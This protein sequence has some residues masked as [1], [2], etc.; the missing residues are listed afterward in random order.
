MVLC[1]NDEL[2]HPMGSDLAWRESLYFNFHDTANGIGGWI[3]LWVVPNQPQ[4]SGMLVSFYHGGW[5]DL[6]VNEKA[7]AAPGH[8]L[9][10]GDRWIYCFQRNIDQLA[11][12]DFDDINLCGLHLRRLEPL[13]RYALSFQDEHGDGFDLVSDFTT[14]PFDYADGVNPTPPWMAQNRYHR[15]H[16]IRGILTIGGTTYDIDCTGDSDHSWGLRDMAIFGD[17]LFKMWSLQTPDGKLS[18]SVLQQGVGD[19]EVALGFVS[20]DGVVASARTI[21]SSARFDDNGVQSDIRLHIVDDQDR[22]I[23]ASFDAM[24]SYVGWGTSSHFWG[25][26]GVGNFQVEGYGSVPGLTSYFWPS[27]FTPETLAA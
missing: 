26:E 15:S 10:D 20:I 22:S 9:R 27:R 2:R 19:K 12:A 5:P 25:Y 24:H 21:E 23:T 4:P 7:M 14:L 11:G 6:A 3:Y 18:L 8:C 17:N 16:E 1:A 13:K